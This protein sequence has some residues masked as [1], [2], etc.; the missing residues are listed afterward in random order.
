M[1]HWTCATFIV[2]TVMFC[3]S[4]CADRSPVAPSVPAAT[5][6]DA[7][8]RPS[9][10][11]P[12]RY[13]LSFYADRIGGLVPVSSLP[14]LSDELILAA[15]VTTIS[16]VAATT[17]TAT[18]EYCSYKGLPPNDITRA[19]EAPLEAC[20]DGSANWARLTSIGLDAPGCP[21]L[22]PGYAC[23]DFG[24][25]R[26]P[27]KIGFRFRFSAQKSGIASGTSVPQNFEWTAR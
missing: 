6:V 7:S 24:I 10:A 11:T 17:G 8:V 9:A 23:M 1:P 2:S 15:H 14:V 20:A 18:F 21:Q 22:G 19:D 26:I 25:V 16:G 4:A 12:G 27:R 13:E 5:D 3:V